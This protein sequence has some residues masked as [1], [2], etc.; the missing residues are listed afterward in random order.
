MPV[1]HADSWASQHWVSNGSCVLKCPTHRF[2]IQSNK[3]KKYPPNPL[4]LQSTVIL[5]SPKSLHPAGAV[6]LGNAAF[7]EGTGAIVLGRVTC[8]GDEVSL[9]SC[10]HY[11]PYYYSSHSQDAGVRCQRGSA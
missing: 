5:T 2:I 1:L 6:G 3:A 8:R 7:G 9:T 4:Y 11:T 10:Q